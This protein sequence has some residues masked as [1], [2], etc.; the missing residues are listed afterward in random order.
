MAG[1]QGLTFAG[2]KAVRQVECSR[3]FALTTRV[4]AD[5]YAGHVGFPEGEVHEVHGAARESLHLPF[6]RAQD[7]NA[8]GGDVREP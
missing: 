1:S 2:S 5:V 3:M 8:A 7:R 4:R 6:D